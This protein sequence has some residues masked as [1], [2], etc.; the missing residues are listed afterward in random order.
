MVEIVGIN[1]D[2]FFRFRNGGGWI[3]GCTHNVGGTGEA[4]KIGEEWLILLRK[5]GERRGDRNRVAM[6]DD[7]PKVGGRGGDFRSEEHTSELQSRQYLVCRL[8]LDKKISES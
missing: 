2:V 6:G 8:L 1:G 7:S 3:N 4:E 5:F